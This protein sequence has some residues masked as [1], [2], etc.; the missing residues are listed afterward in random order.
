[1]FNVDDFSSAMMTT[2]ENRFMASSRHVVRLSDVV[3][4][5]LLKTPSHSYTKHTIST[6]GIEEELTRLN[7]YFYI[8]L[9]ELRV[10]ASVPHFQH[11]EE[12]ET[13]CRTLHFFHH[14]LTD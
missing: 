7:A 13:V 4:F 1:M 11:D 12:N 9:S 8:S 2:F 14:N 5:C 6:R 3:H 10:R